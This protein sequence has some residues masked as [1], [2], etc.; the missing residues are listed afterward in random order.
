MVP[1]ES[2]IEGKVPVLERVP[3]DRIPPLTDAEVAASG[4][5]CH[6]ESGRDDTAARFNNYI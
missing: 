2:E 4:W 3:L 6:G 5:V 1:T